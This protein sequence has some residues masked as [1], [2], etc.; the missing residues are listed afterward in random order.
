[1]TYADNAE[2]YAAILEEDEVYNGLRRLERK[3][4]DGRR[5]ERKRKEAKKQQR[6]DQF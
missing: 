3:I 2:L 5:K 6:F 4:R 1:M